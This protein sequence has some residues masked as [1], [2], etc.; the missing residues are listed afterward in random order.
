[1]A[2]SAVEQLLPDPNTK[3]SATIG[4]VV[5]VGCTNGGTQLANPE[6]WHGFADHYTNL[7]LGAIRAISL[8]PGAQGWTA[9][10]GQCISGMGTFVKALAT[11]VITDNAVPGLAA[12]R[13]DGQ[14]VTDISRPQTKSPPRMRVLRDHHQFRCRRSDG[15]AGAPELPRKYLAHAGLA[16]GHGLRRAE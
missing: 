1:V 5:F 11:G 15:V 3:W 14:F 8:I 12:M 2:R 10:A 16:G 9:I 13:P 6:N 4:R 7:A